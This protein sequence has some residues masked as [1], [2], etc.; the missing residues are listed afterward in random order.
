MDTLYE[1]L[2]CLQF[3]IDTFS[4]FNWRALNRN[5]SLG[6]VRKLGQGHSSE[7]EITKERNQ[8]GETRF[9][10]RKESEC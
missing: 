5:L 7:D 4:D 9:L 8:Y 10:R 3:R 6:Q 2:K 1:N